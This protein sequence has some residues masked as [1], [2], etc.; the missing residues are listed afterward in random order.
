[1]SVAIIVPMAAAV[2]RKTTESSSV[3]ARPRG[4]STTRGPTRRARPARAGGRDPAHVEAG[5]R[6][7]KAR[8]H[9]RAQPT[10]RTRSRDRPREDRGEEERQRGEE[11]EREDLREEDLPPRDRPGQEERHRPLREL[12]GDEVRADD[13]DEERDQEERADAREGPAEDR[14]RQG[15][16]VDVL[17]EVVA[18]APGLEAHPPG[19]VRRDVPAAEIAVH[20][21]DPRLHARAPVPRRVVP[22][23]VPPLPCLPEDHDGEQDAE[24]RSTTRKRFR[25]RIFRVSFSTS[26]VHLI[27]SPLGLLEE[28]LL[29]DRPPF[30]VSSA[31]VPAASVRPR[32]T[33]AIRSTSFS[34]SERMLAGD[35]DREAA[36]VGEVADQL[37]HLADPPGRAVRRLVEIIRTAGSPRS[38]WAMPI[39]CPHP[40]E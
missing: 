26:P 13:G 31:S 3:T 27:R 4:P 14:R 29:R 18:E 17:L 7:A 25:R 39:R 21:G 6:E 36:V 22:L 20:P 8:D 35:E 10:S 5:V 12:R 1:M 2:E 38:A 11:D 40:E 19:P 34:I 23:G 9:G 32:W 16:G 37:A 15:L 24:D 30:P 28:E 33:M